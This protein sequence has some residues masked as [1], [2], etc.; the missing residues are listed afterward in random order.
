MIGGSSFAARGAG[1]W[2]AWERTG[3]GAYADSGQQARTLR[4]VFLGA[5]LL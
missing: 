5:A 3:V 4:G 2:E 1:A